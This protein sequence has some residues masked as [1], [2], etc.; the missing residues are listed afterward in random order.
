M[1]IITLAY[2]SITVLVVIVELLEH[3]EYHEHH[4]PFDS[5]GW[6]EWI[7]IA[8]KARACCLLYDVSDKGTLFLVLFQT[9]H[10]PRVVATFRVPYFF[11]RLSATFGNGMKAVD[12]EPS[13]CRTGLL[14]EDIPTRI[15]TVKRISSHPTVQDPFHSLE[16]RWKYIARNKLP[17]VLPAIELRA[18]IYRWV[19][20]ESL[21]AILDGPTRMEAV[22]A[23]Q[24][25]VA[26]LLAAMKLGP[27]WRFRELVLQTSAVLSGTAVGQLIDPSSTSQR[28]RLLVSVFTK[29]ML[30]IWHDYLIAH[31]WSLAPIVVGRL[32]CLGDLSYEHPYHHHHVSVI[33]RVQRSLRLQV[34]RN[35]VGYNFWMSGT[36]ISVGHPTFHYLGSLARHRQQEFSEDVDVQVGYRHDRIAQ[37]WET[38]MGC[39]RGRNHGARSCGSRVCSIR[40][41]L[42]VEHFL[43]FPWTT[44]YQKFK[45]QVHL[46]FVRGAR[47]WLPCELYYLKRNSF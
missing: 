22:L 8:L 15:S 14:V 5:V 24:Y 19:C 27:M 26:E 17:V 46:D 36:H 20:F 45:D 40:T 21:I 41:T 1:P 4:G 16:F 39:L 6:L 3:H 2:F 29:D 33:L 30:S 13:P 18:Q 32:E 38:A 12:R 11:P 44:Q 43:S 25:R 10:Q 7:T 34:F 23:V 47:E 37:D 9:F 35:G 42:A 31:G 28:R